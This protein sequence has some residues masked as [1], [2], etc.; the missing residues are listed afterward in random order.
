MDTGN[1]QVNSKNLTR[2]EFLMRL[3]T[4]LEKYL[5]RIVICPRCGQPGILTITKIKNRRKNKIYEYY[6][7]IVHH[8]NTRHI[9]CSLDDNVLNV[10]RKLKFVEVR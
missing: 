2:T 9:V 1:F 8:Y 4:E 10:V 3:R 6:Y 5:G 7:L